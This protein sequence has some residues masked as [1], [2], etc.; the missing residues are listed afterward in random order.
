[1]TEQT[2]EAK[3]KNQKARNPCGSFCI[4]YDGDNC[5]IIVYKQIIAHH[6]FEKLKRWGFI[7]HLFI[8]AKYN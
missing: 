2:H 6:F 5:E 7:P 3:S 1:M 4:I 8:L